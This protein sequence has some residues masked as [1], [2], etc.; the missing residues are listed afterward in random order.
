M[1]SPEILHFTY[2]GRAVKIK[3]VC[4]DL[5]VRYVV[6]G[7]VRKSGNRVRITAQLIDG[8][9]EGHL[10]AD[11]YD[12]TL[13]DIFELQDQVTYQIIE[14]LKV[15][16]LSGERKAIKNT[17]TSNIKAYELYL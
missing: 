4:A 8:H 14:A 5:G 17:P 6:E 7:S 16:L 10:W 13:D 3:E 15:R 9:T 1:L 2:K 11:R 12:G